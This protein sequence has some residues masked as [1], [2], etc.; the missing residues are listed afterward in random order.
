MRDRAT[1]PLFAPEPVKEPDRPKVGAKVERRI[2]TRVELEAE[3]REQVEAAR[4]AERTLAEL[5]E[6]AAT[7]PDPR[8]A[9]DLWRQVESAK[10]ATYLAWQKAC[11]LPWVDKKTA[12]APKREL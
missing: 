10:W 5:E 8:R 3:L 6:E 9:A 1:I 4:A 11:P 7:E 2:R 12:K